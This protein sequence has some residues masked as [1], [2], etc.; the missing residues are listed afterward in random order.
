VRINSEGVRLKSADYI[1]TWLSVFW[2]EG[3]ERIEDFARSSRLTT[4]RATELAGAPVGWTPIN[5]YIAVETSHVVRM[6]VA[7]GQRRGRLQQAY[8]ALQAKD[9]ISGLVDAARQE[10]EMTKLKASL[11]V[12][13]NQVSWTEYIRSI[14]LAGFVRRSNLTSN[15]NV[16]YSYVLFLLGRTEFGVPLDRLR[17]LIARWLF[18]S[19][20]TGRYTGSSESQIQKD[21]DRV[22]EVDPGDA[23]GFEKVLEQIIDSQLTDDYWSY[24]MPQDLVTSGTSVSPHYQCYLASL[25]ILDAKMFMLDEKVSDWMDP[26]Q[27]AVKGTEGHHLFPR[28]YQENVLGI[29]DFKRINQV[30]N[31]APTDWNTNIAISD[32]PPSEYWPRLVADR[33]TSPGWLQ[34]QMYWHALPQGWERMSYDAFLDER[35]KLMAQVTRDAYQKLKNGV[36]PAT[37]TIVVADAAEPASEQ[38]IADLIQGGVLNAGDLLDPTDGGDAVDAVIT[39]SGTVELDGTDQYDFLSEAMRALGVANV[40]AFDYWGVEIGEDLIPLRDRLS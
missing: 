36:E 39:D 14:R 13:T 7:V 23:A 10:A 1:L 2:P 18:M 12:V 34:H 6:M 17:N 37:R 21:I 31:F 33:S 9:K 29:S 26:S 22:D 30:A 3:R 24:S 19:Q 11:D 27:P 38:S 5:P 8:A 28:A 16:V 4:Q 40:D 35:R 15:M 25:N 20:L 32:D